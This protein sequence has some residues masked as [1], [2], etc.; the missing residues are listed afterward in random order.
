MA[1]DSIHL[2]H[3]L[4]EEEADE[5]EQKIEAFRVTIEGVNQKVD[6]GEHVSSRES[7]EIA[8]F[9]GDLI[10]LALR[11]AQA[12]IAAALEDKLV[13]VPLKWDD[14]FNLTQFLDDSDFNPKFR[15]A[16]LS[17]FTELGLRQ[18]KVAT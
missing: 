14:R 12:D 10:I 1:G 9:L 8:N 15:A 18:S 2:W 16:L 7:R 3:A 5:L 6:R 17:Y 13:P 11:Y 4:S